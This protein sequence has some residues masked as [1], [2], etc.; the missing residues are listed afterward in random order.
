ME[1]P[2]FQNGIR[3]KVHSIEDRS[4]REMVHALIDEL[5]SRQAE[6]FSPYRRPGRKRGINPVV[7]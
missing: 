4:F 1:F 5:F 2:E 6:P 3:A 7:A